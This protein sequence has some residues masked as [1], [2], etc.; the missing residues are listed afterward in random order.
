[1]CVEFLKGE[2][3]AT[4]LRV[5]ADGRWVVAYKSGTAWHPTQPPPL[6]V[7]GTDDRFCIDRLPQSLWKKYAIAARF[8]QLV[9]QKTVKIILYQ[10]I[11]WI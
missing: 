3:V 8:V 10:V 7:D 4:V 1:M 5:S 6:P 9:R 11:A 2:N